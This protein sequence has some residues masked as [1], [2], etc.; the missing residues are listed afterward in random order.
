MLAGPVWM[1]GCS[2]DT[3]V[4]PPS[5]TAVSKYNAEVPMAWFELQM[6]LIEKSPGFSPP[7]ASRALG[8]SSVA[9]YEAL[10]PGMSG[11]RSLVGQLNGLASVPQISTGSEYHWPTV[12]NSALS[13]I[14]RQ[15]Y[16]NASTEYMAQI[17]ALDAQ[18]T[19]KYKG[20]V[21]TEVLNRSIDHGKA[22]ANAIFEW[23]KT[24]G[25]HEG[26]NRNFPP[27]YTPPTGPGMW[28]P[29]PRSS[30]APQSALQ[31]YWGMNRPFVLP[32]GNPSRDCDPGA[33]YAYSADPNSDFYKEGLEVYNAV[34]NLTTEQRAIAMF[35][36]DDAGKTCTP[37]GHSI[38][39]LCQCIKMKSSSLEFAAHA[40]AKMGIAVADAFISCW[41]S[42]YK[43]N[44]LRPISYIQQVIDPNWNTPAIT[45][46]LDTPPF[47]EYPSGHSV[48]S[49]AAARVLAS[50][51]GDN[52]AF[53][54]HTHDA[55]GKPARSFTSFEAFATEAAISRLYGGI[56]YRAGI[57]RG[58]TQGKKIGDAV[59][60]LKFKN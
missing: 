11:Y 3:T 21:S 9:L 8:Y 4:Q 17:D 45:D 32:A 51:Y 26:Y 24:D 30:G 37:P 19:N 13:Q 57:E 28:V 31:P 44:L 23:S 40:Y 54:D 15:L 58:V 29:T 35:W 43:Y 10:V 33:P 22:V 16:A 36:A 39:I 59:L 34:K 5:T 12:A 25:G 14:T 50:L 46:P 48:Q 53:T 49:G 7:V 47:P 42:K 56:H 38:S 41:E 1:A 60:G 6:K 27:T 20:E 18:F 52:F 2:D 55:A